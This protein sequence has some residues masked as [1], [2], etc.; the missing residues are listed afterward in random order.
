SFD[1]PATISARPSRKRCRYP[2]TLAPLAPLATPTPGVVSPVRVDR[3]PP[4]KRIRD[5]DVDIT[6]AKALADMEA[7]VRVEVGFGIKREDEVE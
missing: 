3:L 5:I 7:D 2:A 4:R 6:A 1:T